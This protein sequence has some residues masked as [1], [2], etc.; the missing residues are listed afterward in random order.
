ME[1]ELKGNTELFE[2]N[3]I[4]VPAFPSQLPFRLPWK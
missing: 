1:F 3:T 2:E 4:T